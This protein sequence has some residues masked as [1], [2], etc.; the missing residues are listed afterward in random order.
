[1]NNTTPRQ[2]LKEKKEL[3]ATAKKLFPTSEKPLPSKPNA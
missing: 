2:A 3:H 1:V